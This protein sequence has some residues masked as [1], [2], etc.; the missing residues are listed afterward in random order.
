MKTLSINEINN[1][2]GGYY[3]TSESSQNFK[4]CLSFFIRTGLI[5]KYD[6]EV[7]WRGYSFTNLNQPD[8]LH[9]NK[10]NFLDIIT[11]RCFFSEIIKLRANK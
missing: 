9:V 10:D 1:V 4:E 3:Y 6:S 2:C 8:Y 7:S 5:E 11:E